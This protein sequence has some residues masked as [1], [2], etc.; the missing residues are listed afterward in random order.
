MRRVTNAGCKIPRELNSE[1]YHPSPRGVQTLSRGK[2]SSQG[3]HD[4]LRAGR[5]VG[6]QVPGTRC[7]RRWSLAS[8]CGTI[9]AAVDAD[10]R[11]CSHNH[12]SVRE[13]MRRTAI[14]MILFNSY[15]H[16]SFVLPQGR[17]LL[18][19]VVFLALAIVEILVELVRLL[20]GRHRQPTR[21]SQSRN[22]GDQ[23]RERREKVG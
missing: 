8:D 20:C 22:V 18:V 1:G 21:V 5:S 17:L 23:T 13:G 6:Y 9:T 15:L 19:V 10:C 4:P 16:R 12:T 11:Y 7:H 2:A 3:H 14:H